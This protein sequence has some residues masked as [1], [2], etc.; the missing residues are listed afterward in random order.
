M[1]KLKAPL[2]SFGAGGKLAKSLVF[3]PWKGI[4]AVREYVIPANP[5]T[6]LQTTQRGYMTAAVAEWHAASYSAVDVT[7]W[8]RY[9][10]TLAKI[11]AGFNAMV[12]AFVNEAIL[13]N[14]WERLTNCTTSSTGPGNLTVEIWSNVDAPVPTCHVGKRKTHFPTSA[15]MVQLDT[16]HWQVGFALDVDTLY[17][18]YID[19]GTSGSDYGRTGIYAQRTDPAA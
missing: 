5:Q 4:N 16:N 7:A 2:L 18:L 8:N 9:A 11:M 15:T 19:L 14:A 12:R 6:T 13:G 3:F 17:Y 1:A 10:G